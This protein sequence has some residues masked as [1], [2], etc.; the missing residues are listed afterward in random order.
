VH[1]HFNSESDEHSHKTRYENHSTE[2]H[3]YIPTIS[4]SITGARQVKFR[5]EMDNNHIHTIHTEYCP[6][7]TTINVVMV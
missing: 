2:S 4:N 6:K 1:P 7:F 5:M 3:M